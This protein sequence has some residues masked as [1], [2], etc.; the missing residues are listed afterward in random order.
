MSELQVK[1][2]KNYINFNGQKY[3]CHVCKSTFIKPNLH[4]KKDYHKQNIQD[5]NDYEFI[6]YF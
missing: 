1:M 5:F 6:V 2:K 4:I 3:Y